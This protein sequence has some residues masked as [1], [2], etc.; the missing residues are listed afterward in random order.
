MGK[1][2]LQEMVADLK[3]RWG[4]FAYR[5]KLVMP[6]GK[7]KVWAA[8][9][10]PTTCKVCKGKNGAIYASYETPELEIPVHQ[11]CRCAIRPLLAILAG[12]ATVDGENGADWYLMM[13][14]EL[15]PNYLSKAAAKKAGWKRKNGNLASVLPGILIEGGIFQNGNGKLP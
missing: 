12:T 6:S 4:D 11:R 13:R 5:G 15:P 7:W 10:T 14:G 9:L 2:L 1:D 8:M 3:L